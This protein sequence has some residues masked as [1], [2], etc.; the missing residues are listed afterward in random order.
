MNLLA[1][2]IGSKFIN[3]RVGGRAS[4]CLDFISFKVSSV[5]GQVPRESKETTALLERASCAHS[6]ARRMLLA[7]KLQKKKKRGE[8][9]RKSVCVCVVCLYVCVYVA[10]SCLLFC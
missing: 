10:V 3:R 2:Q 7:R 8:R 1:H 6:V 9:K 4:G 5:T